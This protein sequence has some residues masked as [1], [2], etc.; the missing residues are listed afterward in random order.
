V[1]R[2]W[3]ALGFNQIVR[4]QGLSAEPHRETLS[5]PDGDIIRMTWEL[6]SLPAIPLEPAMPPFA[7]VSPRLTIVP[8]PPKWENENWSRLGHRYWERLFASR[9]S[10]GPEVTALAA[11]LTAGATTPLE[12]LSRLTRFTQ[13]DVR[14]VAIELGVG[15]YQPH[16]AD[17]VLKNRYGDC[18]DKV[19]LLLSLLAAAGIAGEPALVKTA[20]EGTLDTAL[21]DLGQFDHMIARVQA[22]D[23]VVWVDPT[24][25]SCALGYLPGADQAT[26]GLV[27]SANRARLE[28][29]PT[30]IADDSPLDVALDGALAADG[31]LSGTLSL[32]GRGEAA[33][34]YRAA[35]RR[36]D[37]AEEKR[38]VEGILKDRLSNA[39]LKSYVL[40]G[41]DSL[42]APFRL[43]IDFERDGAAMVMDQTLVVLPEL[44]W[45]SRMEQG[46]QAQE[47]VHPVVLD[48]L[49]TY[50]DRLR[51]APPKGFRPEG[52]IAPASFN[53]RYFSF[54]L[55]AR[56]EGEALVLERSVSNRALLVPARFYA[57]AQGELA[58][59]REAGGAAALRFRKA[60]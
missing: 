48:C 56:A 21:V 51:I 34:E 22:G 16:L 17:E 29:T 14:Y 9:L 18:K 46:F 1:P 45:V 53:G 10:K 3:F 55:D 15:G 6:Q 5:S 60:P 26:Y 40:G 13:S 36:R 44:V 27:V 30:L 33:I 52:T 41:L 4:A 42:D 43:A 31:R 12:K 19:C 49:R 57:D 59:V 32:E 23:R 20:G 11:Q 35:F 7:E 38:L 8:Q 47:R 2:A 50:R 37:A 24:A 25:S 58:R 54:T 28:P 39:R